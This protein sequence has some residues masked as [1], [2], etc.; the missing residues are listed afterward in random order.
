MVFST[1]IANLFLNVRIGNLNGVGVRGGNFR[2][3]SPMLGVSIS[4]LLLD[5][6]SHK[7]LEMK[8]NLN[9]RM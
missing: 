7:G 8:L 9:T 1:S 6:S 2:N 3:Q 4:F 5:A